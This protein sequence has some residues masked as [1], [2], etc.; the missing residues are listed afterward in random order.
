MTEPTP[1]TETIHSSDSMYK[2][3]KNVCIGAKE[4]VLAWVRSKNPQTMEHKFGKNTYSY[5]NHCGKGYEEKCTGSDMGLQELLIALGEE[6][7][8][9]GGEYD[10]KT[11]RFYGISDRQN[12]QVFVYFDLTKNLHNQTEEFYQSLLRTEFPYVYKSLKRNA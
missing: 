3:D 12:R 2:K 9:I 1:S 11:F 4:Q 7:Y 5:C 10:D 6:F 8:G